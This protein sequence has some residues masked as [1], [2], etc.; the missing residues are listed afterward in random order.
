[1]E[2]ISRLASLKGKLPKNIFRSTLGETSEMAEMRHDRI[3]KRNLYKGYISMGISVFILATYSILFFY[4]QVDSY[5]SSQSTINS[6]EDEIKDYNEVKLVDLEEQRSMHQSAYKEEFNKVEANI[7]AVF[8]EGIDKLGIVKRLENFATQI[9]TK[10]PPFEFNSISISEPIQKN[11]YVVLPISTSIHSSVAN[12]EK[13]LRL[14]DISGR[15]DSKTAQKVRLMEISN[16]SIRYR[17][18]D[19]KT[20]EDKGVDFSVKLN[21]Y[22]RA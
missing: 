8:P 11:G 22:S 4:P 17:G 12:F 14:I 20:G 3:K 21:A 19:K 15:L 9:N 6:I 1:M 10:T 2:T 18:V 7:N 5:L 13:F 16:V